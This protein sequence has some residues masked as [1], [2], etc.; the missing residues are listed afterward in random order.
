M[1]GQE[2]AA[3]RA[4]MHSPQCQSDNSPGGSPG[5]KENQADHKNQIQHHPGSPLRHKQEERSRPDDGQRWR[6]AEPD[7]GRLIKAG[8]YRADQTMVDL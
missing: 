2:G 8:F 1:V 3:A 7:A 4:A 5:E 6:P